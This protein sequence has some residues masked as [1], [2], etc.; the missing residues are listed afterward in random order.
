MLKYNIISYIL[1]GIILKSI[2]IIT[3][4]LQFS[5]NKDLRINLDKL[6]GDKFDEFFTKYLDS[7]KSVYE[8]DP[9]KQ[10]VLKVEEY[11]KDVIKHDETKQPLYTEIIGCFKSGEYGIE[12]EIIDPNS[13]KVILNKGKELADVLPFY[14][15]LGI[16]TCES[17]KAILIL[18]NIS[19]YGVKS[20]FQKNFKQYISL[21]VK[22]PIKLTLGTLIPKVF[23]KRIIEKASFNKVRLINYSIPKDLSDRFGMNRGVQFKNSGYMETIFNKGKNNGSNI[24]KEL[25]KYILNAYNEKGNILELQELKGYEYDNIKI[26]VGFGGRT[27]TLMLNNLKELNITEDISEEVEINEGGLPKVESIN[28]LLRIKL[29][30]YMEVSGLLG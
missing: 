8:D 1:G 13:G 3:Y 12:S 5:D 23:L 9:E 10:K 2:G 30:E 4:G 25:G 16:P 11:S 17:E 26:E 19:H 27:K 20:A 18:Q 14:F 28:S 24:V 6:S 15:T 7:R 22:K 21:N 29:K